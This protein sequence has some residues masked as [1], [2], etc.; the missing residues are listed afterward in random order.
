MPTGSKIQGAFRFLTPAKITI[1][2]RI[3][4]R[5]NDGYHQVRLALIPVSL[6]D[7]ISW[8]P[9]GNAPRLEVISAEPLGA[10]ADNLVFRAALAF[11]SASGLSVQGTL[12]LTKHVPSGAG[13]GGGSADA[14]G[15]LVMLNRLHGD[16]LSQHRLWEVAQTLGSDVPF[17]VRP[18]PQWAEGRGEMLTPITGFPRLPLLVVK[19]PFGI[20]TAE[21]YRRVAPRPEAAPFPPLGTPAHVVAALIN[22]F[23][24]ALFPDYPELPRIKARLKAS[25]ASGALLS[26]SGSAV[27]GVFPDAIRRDAA[28]EHLTREEPAWTVLPCDTLKR[29]DYTAIEAAP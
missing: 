10:P 19:P 29:H 17:F 6:Y 13:L 20:S 14:A 2:I 12:R 23:E 5:R 24:P 3:L 26:G 27:F 1:Y 25:G 15:T 9:G 16:P 7:T 4:A 11:Q 8:E 22:D 28:A 21:A 18:C